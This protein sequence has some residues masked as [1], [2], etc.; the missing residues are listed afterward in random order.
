MKALALWGGRLL[1][2]AGFEP[3]FVEDDPRP[4]TELIP[5]A[6]EDD[7]GTAIDV[8]AP[9]ENEAL[10]FVGL[11]PDEARFV[12]IRFELGRY[13]PTLRRLIVR[14][15]AVAEWSRAARYCPTCGFPLEWNAGGRGKSCTNPAGAHRLY[16]RL[17]PAIIVLVEDGERALLGRP[18]SWDPGIYSTIAGFVEPGES[19]EDAVR[20][21]VM[22]ETGVTI[23]DV[24]YVGSEPWPFPRSLMLGFRASAAPGQPVT[25]GAELEDARWFTPAEARAVLDARYGPTPYLET[26]ARRLIEGWLT[27]VG[28]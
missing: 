23:G 7:D 14:A 22:E 18:A 11:A 13:E 10:A 16:P 28:R 25:V 20:R 26:M 1:V 17:D 12:P 24:R 3:L 21:E 4:G 27:S 15:F 9:D 5:L 8:F 19:V 2:R 6:G